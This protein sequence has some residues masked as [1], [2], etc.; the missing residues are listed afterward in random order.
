MTNDQTNL[1]RSAGLRPN[2]VTVSGYVPACDGEEAVLTGI[3][4]AAVWPAFIVIRDRPPYGADLVMSSNPGLAQ[5]TELERERILAELD[6]DSGVGQAD[7]IRMIRERNPA[8]P[9]D[10]PDLD[11]QPIESTAVEEPELPP[12]EDIPPE[13]ARE[14]GEGWG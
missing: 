10:A 5:P 4:E 12:S 6:T 13:V 11:P 7:V 9:P 8:P 3:Y 2:H 1:I 14:L